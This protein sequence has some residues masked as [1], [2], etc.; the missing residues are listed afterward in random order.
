M[1]SFAVQYY[2]AAQKDL[3]FEIIEWKL[4][5]VEQNLLLARFS[6][7][8]ILVSSNLLFYLK[9]FSLTLSAFILF[10]L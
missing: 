9:T 6:N 2:G 1:L 8:G 3:I 5:C 10:K 4:K 7:S